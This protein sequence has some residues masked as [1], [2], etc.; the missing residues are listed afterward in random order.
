MK[1]SKKE[2]KEIIKEL[3]R[4]VKKASYRVV[5]IRRNRTTRQDY[6]SAAFYEQHDK[7]KILSGNKDYCIVAIMPYIR[8]TDIGRYEIYLP[9][10]WKTIIDFE[11]QI[12][13]EKRKH[14]YVFD[15]EGW[16]Y[17]SDKPTLTALYSEN[18]T[19][20]SIPYYCDFFN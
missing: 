12:Y 7:I 16:V 3:R 6:L 8:K 14:C 2:R 11:G 1:M 15:K 5:T 19:L 4:E 18:R 9:G 13:G 17:T 10:K 20:E